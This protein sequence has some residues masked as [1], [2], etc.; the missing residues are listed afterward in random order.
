MEILLI[1][2]KKG[3]SFVLALAFLAE[4]AGGLLLYPHEAKAQLTNGSTLTNGLVGHWTFDGASINWLTGAVTDASGSGNTGTLESTMRA[5]TSTAPGKLGQALVFD[6]APPSNEDGQFMSVNDNASLD[7]TSDI[8]LAAWIRRDAPGTEDGIITKNDNLTWAYELY[9]NSSNQ[10]AFGVNG[11]TVGNSSG[12]V[13]DTDWHHVAA[14]RS[15]TTITFYIDGVASGTATNGTAFTLNTAPVYVGTISVESPCGTGCFDGRLDD[16]R[17]YNRALSAAEITQLSRVGGNLGRPPNNLGLVGYWS[18][19]EATSTQ[20][21]D[22]SGNDNHG[23]LSFFPALPN[24]NSGWTDLGKRGSAIRFD[25]ASNLISIGSPAELAITGAVTTCAWINPDT[26]PPVSGKWIVGR[27][28][29]SIRGPYM[30]YIIDSNEMAFSWSDDSSNFE[31]YTTNDNAIS[32]NTWQ[33]VCAVRVS[34]SEVRLYVNG[35]ERTQTA[36]G[37]VTVTTLATVNYIGSS[38]G[39]GSDIFDGT[40]DEVRVYNRALGATEIAALAGNA[41]GSAG[42]VRAGVSSKTLTN[43]T[44]LGASGGLVGHW[45]FDGGDFGTAVID[46]SGNGRNG[47]VQGAAT[48]TVKAQG[49]LGQGVNFNETGYVITVPDNAGLNFGSAQDFSVSFYAQA[50][51]I[52]GTYAGMVGDKLSRATNRLGYLVAYVNG[53][54]GAYISDGVDEATIFSSADAISDGAWHHIVLTASRTGNATLYID[55]VS[56]G[57]PASITA[58]GNIDDP[59]SPVLIGDIGFG[60]QPFDGGIDDVRIYNKVLTPSEVRQ[61]SRLGQVTVNP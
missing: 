21:T 49:K 24:A 44:T 31:T 35:V 34:T 5:T 28:D 32:V 6:G 39:T 52:V 41:P 46:G 45:T 16:T 14:T 11:S 27:T 61:L 50:R 30:M 59:G 25:G 7:I 47:F 40:I 57:T 58:V 54:V 13:S 60:G 17:I 2:L 3:A 26:A 36:S 19:N 48:S 15:G 10:L 23:T 55:G 4:L 38:L 43:G 29:A 12:T 1:N 53:G 9:V 33:H 18:F 42:A 20:A 37:N 22:F 56:V 51:P 8:T